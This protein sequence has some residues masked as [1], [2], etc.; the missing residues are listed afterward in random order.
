MTA[1]ESP[2]AAPP[3]SRG[4]KLGIGIHIAAD[5]AWLVLFGVCLAG[6]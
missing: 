6:A 2:P 5:L 3:L 1:P 4:Q